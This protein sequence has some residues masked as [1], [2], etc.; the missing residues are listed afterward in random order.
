VGQN[1]V[2]TAVPQ[3]FTAAGDVSV[4]YDMVFTNQTASNIKSYGPLTIA[5]GESWENNDLTL[6]AYGS[7]KINLN[8]AG[9]LIADIAGTGTA[10]AL[11]HSSQSGTTDQQIV[12]CTSSPTADY[13]EMYPVANGITF[14]DVVV[15]GTN[16]VVTQDGQTIK[17]LVKSSSSYQANV[18]GIVSDNYGDFTSAGYNIDAEDNPMPVALVGRVPVKMSQLSA[19]LSAGDYLTTSN[20]AG[21]ATKATRAG[22][23]IGRALESW[24]P[25]KETVMVFVGTSWYDPDVFLADNG[26]LS[27]GGN[28][29]SG[30]TVNNNGQLVSKIGTFAEAFVGELQAGRVQ[31]KDIVLDGVDLKTTLAALNNRLTLSE[32]SIASLTTQT[33]SNSNQLA[34]LN[35]SVGALNTSFS[36][37]LLGVGVSTPATNSGRLIDTSSGAYLSAGGVWTNVSDVRLKENFVEL[38]PEEILTKINNLPIN[39]WNY[40]SEDDVVTHI[41]PTA[42][43]FYSAFQ[44]GGDPTRIS[45]IDPAGVALAGIQG[46]SA[47]LDNITAELRALREAVNTGLVDTKNLIA[48]RITAGRISTNR[49]TVQLD[50]EFNGTGLEVKNK[51]GETLLEVNREGETRIRD[52]VAQEME[53][54]YLNADQ[55]IAQEITTNEIQIDSAVAN[56]AAIENLDA[57]SLSA[58]QAAIEA[59]QANSAS[60][61]GTLRA[62]NIEGNIASSSITDLEQRVRSI[63]SRERAENANSSTEDLI[64]EDFENEFSDMSDSVSNLVGQAVPPTATGSGNLSGLLAQGADVELGAISAINLNLES[65]LTIG[66]AGQNLML[67][68]NM[69]AFTVDIA[70]ADDSCK[71]FSFQPSGEGRLS[72]LADAMVLSRDGGLQIHTD[73][74]V[75]GRLTAQGGLST[76]LITALPGSDIEINLA[77]APTEEEMLAEA[78]FGSDILG[79][80]TSNRSP[81]DLIIRGNDNQEVAAFTA[82]GS[83]RF[84]K[85]IIASEEATADA[86]SIDTSINTNATTGTA[87]IKAGSTEFLIRNSTITE[88]SQ[89]YITPTSSTRN[90]VV[91]IKAKLSDYAQTPDTNEAGFIV[92][93]DRPIL[94]DISFNWWIIN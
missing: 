55:I 67:S 53:A 24:S 80:S 70:C 26:T 57:T 92:A 66:Q 37:G 11:C 78:G 19:P 39:R 38:D 75:A 61:A 68:Q 2:T 15:L 65:V 40:I 85:L 9:G 59:L 44:T 88:N 3:E 89:I 41:G 54:R 5:S 50:D 17:Q 90:Q 31:A 18:I 63:I 22:T 1:L 14:G 13:A 62:E 72:F 93:V 91:F 43:D 27:I 16:N 29:S 82:S 79:T 25:G 21:K 46:L 36:T 23:V 48:D 28:S 83:A 49:L 12:D 20:E 35:N 32:G 71:T 52:L 60:I 8:G 33:A 4:A 56:S 87:S 34:A 77:S 45:T 47:R 42:Q 10:Y 30:Y 7:G 86:T 69:L 64:T 81:S 58:R 74:L 84:Q 94:E 73:V 76:S 6:T 51:Q